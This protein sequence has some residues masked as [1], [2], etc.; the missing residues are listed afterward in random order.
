VDE[1]EYAIRDGISCYYCTAN[2]GKDDFSRVESSQ[3]FLVEQCS[4][5][6]FYYWCFQ[7]VEYGDIVRD[8][9]R[10]SNDLPDY[11]LCINREDFVSIKKILYFIKKILLLY[12]LGLLGE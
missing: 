3:G 11:R 12:L 4:I 10:S 7:S 8:W 6:S 2:H 5:A 1:L 9:H